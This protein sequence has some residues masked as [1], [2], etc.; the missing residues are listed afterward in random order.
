MRRLSDIDRIDEVL[1]RGTL[2]EAEALFERAALIMKLRRQLAAV[3][4]LPAKRT[5]RRTEQPALPLEEAGAK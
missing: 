4:P 2:A 5:R 1:G 3:A